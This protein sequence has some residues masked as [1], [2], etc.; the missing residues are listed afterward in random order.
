MSTTTHPTEPT[1]DEISL[2]LMSLIHAK[3]KETLSMSTYP[4][5]GAFYRPPAKALI[6]VLPIGT[7]LTLIAEPENQYDPNAVAVW[8]YSRDI[9]EGAAHDKL[10]ETLPAFGTDLDTVLSQEAWHLGYIAKEMAKQ[11]RENDVVP[12]DSPIEGSFSLS[13][14]GA[15]RVRLTDG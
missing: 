2:K 15:P 6:D 3:R 10:S 11:L 1:F 8:L 12:I 14:G 7:P 13:S 5:V 4:L 9:P